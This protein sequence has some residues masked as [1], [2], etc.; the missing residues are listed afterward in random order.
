MYQMSGW[1]AGAQKI[2]DFSYLKSCELVKNCSTE[3][4]LEISSALRHL[5][6]V[7]MRMNEFEKAF[8]A[9]DESLRLRR[10]WDHGSLWIVSLV[11][12]LAKIKRTLGD[13]KQAEELLDESR[14]L[15]ESLTFNSN[16]EHIH[17]EITR[18]KVK[19]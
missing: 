6:D 7:N 14:R 17:S 13:V 12:R 19:E 18:G 16:G 11:K 10:K 15:E 2:F 9:G 4:E 3:F 1:L 8:Q 5:M